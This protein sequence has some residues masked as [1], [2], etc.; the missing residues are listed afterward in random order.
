MERPEADERPPLARTDSPPVK[1]LVALF[2]WEMEP[3]VMVT[4][5]VEERPAV[6]TPAVKVEVAVPVALIERTVVVPVMTAWPVTERGVPGVV[7]PMPRLPAESILA[8]SPPAVEKFN[9]FAPDDHIPVS[10]S[11]TKETDGP[12]TAPRG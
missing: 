11:P 12:P 10:V 4:P 9:V 6:E 2:D 3:A 1:V 8:L 7:V 5:P